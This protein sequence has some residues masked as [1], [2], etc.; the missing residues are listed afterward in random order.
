MK[1]VCEASTY[2]CSV[3]ETGPPSAA[4]RRAIT[5]PKRMVPVLPPMPMVPA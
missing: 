2:Q 5:L 1:G 3:R 4:A